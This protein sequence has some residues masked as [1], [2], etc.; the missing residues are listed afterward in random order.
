MGSR[1]I[2]GSMKDFEAAD[3]M[4]LEKPDLPDERKG[5]AWPSCSICLE[6]V[7]D[8]AKRSTAKLQCGHEFHLG[9]D[10]LPLITEL[11]HF[12]ESFNRMLERGSIH[13]SGACL[14]R[15]WL[16]VLL[17]TAKRNFWGYTGL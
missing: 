17:R 3:V 12:F 4:D 2:K 15:V 14:L 16:G 10:F 8:Q 5:S 13:V 11:L 7:L 9:D 1:N 6:L